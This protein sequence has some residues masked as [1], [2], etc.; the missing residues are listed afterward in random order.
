MNLIL[1]RTILLSL[2]IVVTGFLG[3]YVYSNDTGD[4]FSQYVVARDQSDDYDALFD[5]LNFK[6]F[7]IKFEQ[8]V[9][10]DMILNMQSH[11]DQ[12]G[13]YID[14]TTYPVDITYSD[15]IDEFSVKEVGFR[16]KSTTSRNVLRTY[17][18]R[19]R[20]VYH[21]TTFQL[22]FNETFTYLNNTN[23]YE[24]LNK[25]EVFNLEQLN[26]EYSQIYSGEYDET[27]ISEA[28]T[29][30]L[31]EQADILVANA[32][33]CLVY[34]VIGEKIVNY[35][36][37]TIIEPIDTEYVKNHF[38]SDL[39]R[40]YGDLYKVT[41]VQTEGDLKLDYEGYIGISDDEIRYTYS[42]RN[43]SLNGLRRTHNN[44]EKFINDI[45]D[46]DYFKDNYENIIDIDLFIRYLAI[47]CLV[48]NTDEI[49]Y[50]FNN[51]YT[52]FDVYTNKAML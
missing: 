14:N 42:L 19:D 40:N 36:F 51:Y 10:D 39:A 25:R 11:F 1:K 43:N 3:Y 7:T 48:G 29:H 26:F 44:L 23:V 31:Y 47:A 34:L 17:D 27:M 20:E 32:S 33:Y 9:F 28:Y 24:V 16:T 4:G 49:R 50:N 37:Y 41:D 6:T 38:D 22:Q 5:D 18:W 15:S 52:Y 30:Y 8:T 12:Y 45:N 46:F 21:Q 13:N 2:L 35:G